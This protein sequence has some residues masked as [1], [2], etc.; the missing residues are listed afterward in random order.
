[1]EQEHHEQEIY[2]SREHKQSRYDKRL[3]LKI[4]KRLKIV[5]PEKK[6]TV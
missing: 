2:A 4:V 5:C 1:M 6:P 3:I